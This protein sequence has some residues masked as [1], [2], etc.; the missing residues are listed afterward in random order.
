[1]IPAAISRK[2]DATVLIAEAVERDAKAAILAFCE[3]RGYP[4]LGRIKTSESI[5]EKIETGRFAAWSDI[6]DIFA[7]TIVVPTLLHEESVLDFLKQTFAEV[8]VKRRGSSKKSPNEFRFDATR[9]Y[10]RL[11]ITPG[12]PEKKQ[13]EMFR[14]EVQVKSA[15]EH[16]WSAATHDII[17]KSGDIDWKKHRL[18][19]QLKA[20]VEQLDSLVIAF[21]K[22]SEHITQHSWPELDSKQQLLCGFRKL[23]DDGAIPV[24]LKPKDWTRFCDNS[25]ALLGSS[26]DRPKWNEVIPKAI[27]SATTHA[28]KEGQTIPRSVSLL[29]WAMAAWI[30]DGILKMPLR[31]YF[32]LITPQLLEFYPR[33]E[34]IRPIFNIDG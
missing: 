32:A 12:L 29:Q 18:A 7:C 22:S 2:H 3:S 21:D 31:K 27:D 16:A 19:A 26:A 5:A 17:Y 9:F 14:F 20:A 4:Y 8:E 33:A 28:A 13:L 15:F 10:G 1:M 23:I 25:L 6:N 11:S 24:E 30:E 34:E